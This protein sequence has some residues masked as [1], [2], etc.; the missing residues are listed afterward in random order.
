MNIGKKSEVSNRIETLNNLVSYSKPLHLLSNE[1]SNYSWDYTE[2]PVI[3]TTKHLSN[4]LKRCILG[5]I[6]VLEVENWANLIECREDLDYEELNYE[7]IEEIIF[8]LAN[9]ELEGDLNMSIVKKIAES[10]D[11]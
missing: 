2:L 11:L 4:I 7:R 1:L 3:L 10:L 5:D 8:R 6:S 9:P